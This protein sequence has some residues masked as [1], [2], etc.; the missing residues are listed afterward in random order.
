MSQE[1]ILFVPSQPPQP[2]DAQQIHTPAP[3][4]EQEQVADQALESRE[5]TQAAMTLMGLHTGIV[6][7]HNLAVQ[8]LRD[9]EEEDERH[10]KGCGC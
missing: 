6:M 2:A 5:E 3:T 4:A 9:H 8:S 1:I 7:L 10:P